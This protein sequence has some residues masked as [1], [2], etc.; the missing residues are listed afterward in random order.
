MCWGDF[1]SAKFI[2]IFWNNR[3]WKNKRELIF[4]VNKR[5][6]TTWYVCAASRSEE[7]KE[8]GSEKICTN[9]G[10]VFTS[11]AVEAIF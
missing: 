2:S 4:K 6:Y 11:F 9:E 1:F 5:I 8:S 3:L 10:K 7:G